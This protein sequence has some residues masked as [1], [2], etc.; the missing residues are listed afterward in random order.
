MKILDLSSRTKR[1]L[2]VLSVKITQRLKFNLKSCVYVHSLR[3]LRENL[4][5]YSYPTPS[6][7]VVRE[8]QRPTYSKN[9]TDIYT[10]IDR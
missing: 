4:L 9:S 3:E 2:R 6:Q 5:L 7:A 1:I 8:I 10:L